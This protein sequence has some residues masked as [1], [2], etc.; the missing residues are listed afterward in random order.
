MIAEVKP[1]D[2]YT[3]FDQDDYTEEMVNDSL[4][5]TVFAD[6]TGTD[7]EKRTEEE[8]KLQTIGYSSDE[9]QD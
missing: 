2:V 6:S 8:E 5:T 9:R 1:A 4:G 7:W 3:F